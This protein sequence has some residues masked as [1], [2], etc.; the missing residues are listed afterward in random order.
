M[1][2]PHFVIKESLILDLIDKH[3]ILSQKLK[4]K[5]KITCMIILE[6]SFNPSQNY[7]NNNIQEHK[8]VSNFR[9]LIN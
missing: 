2:Q 3:K 4:K 7:G 5:N 6:F 9:Q 1:G 8:F